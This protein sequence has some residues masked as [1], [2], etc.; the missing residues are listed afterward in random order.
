NPTPGASA[1]QRKITDD[2]NVLQRGNGCFARRAGGTGHH[3]IEGVPS[4]RCFVR[5]GLGLAVLLGPLPLENDGQPINDDVQETAHEQT[6][7]QAGAGEQGRRGS[8]ELHWRHY[9]LSR[10]KTPREGAA[11]SV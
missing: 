4:L 9:C 2:R 7:Q 10:K 8:Q 3:E 5:L 1:A 6:Q 11:S